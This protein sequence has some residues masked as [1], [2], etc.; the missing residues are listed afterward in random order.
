[1]REEH[2]DLAKLNAN[3][4]CVASCHYNWKTMFEEDCIGERGGTFEHPYDE[5]RTRREL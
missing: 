3:G 1:M 5:D 4:K 2:C